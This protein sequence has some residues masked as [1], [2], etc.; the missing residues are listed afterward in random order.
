MGVTVIIVRI[1]SEA[2]PYSSCS[3]IGFFGRDH[4]MPSNAGTTHLEEGQARVLK[5]IKKKC[6][7]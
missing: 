5:L 1:F 4:R 7:W 6:S 3:H 2:R